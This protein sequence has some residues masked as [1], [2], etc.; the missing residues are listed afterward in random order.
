MP[1]PGACQESWAT[2]ASYGSDLAFLAWL[3]AVHV[4]GPQTYVNE[5]PFDLFVECFGSL[6][7]VLWGSRY[8]SLADL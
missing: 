6:V 7:Y 1:I 8:L 4:P 5:L 2:L 3:L